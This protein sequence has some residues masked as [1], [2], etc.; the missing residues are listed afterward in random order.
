MKALV[1]DARE[2]G[3]QRHH[4]VKL[5]SRTRKKVNMKMRAL[6]E[7]LKKRRE[8]VKRKSVRLTIRAAIQEHWKCGKVL[9]H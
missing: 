3:H 8:I 5:M 9:S 1:T 2:K 4:H 6:K 7:A